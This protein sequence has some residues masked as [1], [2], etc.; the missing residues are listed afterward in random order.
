[1]GE[2]S[3]FPA[4]G[5]TMYYVVIVKRINSFIHSFNGIQL[6]VGRF[7]AADGLELW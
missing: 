3:A 2:I 6:M 1:M 5:R 4:Y 7:A